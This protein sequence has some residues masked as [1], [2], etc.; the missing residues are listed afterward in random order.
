MNISSHIVNGRMSVEDFVHY[1]DILV[2]NMTSIVS[3]LPNVKWE[4]SL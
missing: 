2:R 4:S 1:S 3:L